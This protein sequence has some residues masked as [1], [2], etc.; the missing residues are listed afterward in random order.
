MH[1]SCTGLNRDLLGKKQVSDGARDARNN[2][3]YCRREEKEPKRWTHDIT[4]DLQVVDL[5]QEER[6]EGVLEKAPDPQPRASRVLGFGQRPARLPGLPREV[7]VVLPSVVAQQQNKGRKRG[8]GRGTVFQHEQR[9]REHSCAD[10]FCI[11]S[12]GDMGGGGGGSGL[13]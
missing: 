4:H 11:P 6:V 8:G 9:K 12:G 2:N 1:V 10:M 5:Q 13:L 3:D 7:R